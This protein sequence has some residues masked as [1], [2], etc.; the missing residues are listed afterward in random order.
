VAFSADTVIV[1]LTVRKWQFKAAASSAQRAALFAQLHAG[2]NPAPRTQEFW[3]STVERGS[4]S[5]LPL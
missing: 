2:G 4:R 1:T 5:P 3:L